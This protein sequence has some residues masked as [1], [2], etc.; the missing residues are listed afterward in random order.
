M[1]N[2]TKRVEKLE[3]HVRNLWTL[4]FVLIG[5]AGID[6]YSD[7]Q[8][9]KR[10]ERRETPVNMG[11]VTVKS[12]RVEDKHGAERIFLGLE[13]D[14]SLDSLPD[15]FHPGPNRYSA[16]LLWMTQPAA[17]NGRR[18]CFLSPR[19]PNLLFSNEGKVSIFSNRQGRE[20]ISVQ[21]GHLGPRIEMSCKYDNG[22]YFITE[23]RPHIMLSTDTRN[24]KTTSFYWDPE[25]GIKYR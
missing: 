14:S 3:R 24:D 2:E 8:V 22:D 4:V 15:D 17:P 19:N 21:V 1:E 25:Q 16:P 11:H 18:V 7:I 10:G 6:M 20:E 9:L 13:K 12:L 23:Y 5:V